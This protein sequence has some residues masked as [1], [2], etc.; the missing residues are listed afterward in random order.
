MKNYYSVGSVSVLPVLSEGTWRYKGARKVVICWYMYYKY[1][2]CI[3][4]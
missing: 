2:V 1:K 4:R 3:D